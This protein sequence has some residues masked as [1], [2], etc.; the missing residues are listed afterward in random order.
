MKK[1]VLRELLERRKT[2][3]ASVFETDKVGILSMK[4]SKPKKAKKGDK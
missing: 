1:A 4:P 2:Y 3:K